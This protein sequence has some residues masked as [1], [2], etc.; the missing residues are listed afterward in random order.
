MKVRVYPGFAKGQIV[1]PPSKSLLHRSIICA[2]MANG[3]SI[4]KNIVMSEDI[5]ATI[6]AFKTMGVKIE[7]LEN[8]LEI[9]SSGIL[10]FF[11]DEIIDCKESGSTIRF[12]MPLFANKKGIYFTGKESLL[13]RPFKI[14]EDI[15]KKNNVIFKKIDGKIYIQNEL[16]ANTYEVL[17]NISSQFISGLLFSLP[18]K[19]S[20]S[21][22]K[23][24]GNLES[25]KYVDMTIDV[26][27]E[28]GISIS[29]EENV[30]YI[31][32]NQKYLP[33]NYKVESDYSQLAFFAVAGIINGDIAIQNLNTE[34]LQPDFEIIN[35]IEKMGGK[36]IKEKN[37]Y[38]FIKSETNGINIDV[39][40]NPDIAPILSILAAVSKGETCFENAQRLR[41]KETD[42]LKATSESLNLL[43]VKCKVKNDSFTV[44]GQ[45]ILQ[46]NSFSSYNDHRM[47]MSI[48]IA[49]LRANSPITIEGAQAVNKSYPDFFEDLKSLGVKIEYL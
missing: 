4:I 19:K 27:K 31:K 14:Y 39:S 32:G 11:G 28:F 15:F 43:G 49:A 46:G 23:I 41:Y 40:Q 12:L 20:D 45:N 3:K 34:S 8:S 26:L 1:V 9:S 13:N 44:H 21:I 48:S 25:K 2:C 42:R 5:K 33:S 17:G 47:V 35:L 6:N 10:P 37:I 30:Y 16:Q 38:K 22:I 24:I 36:I 7:K 18:L 29:K